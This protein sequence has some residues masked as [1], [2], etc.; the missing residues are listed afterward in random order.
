[1][2]APAHKAKIVEIGRTTAVI[3]DAVVRVTPARR[4]IAAGHHASVVSV[5]QCP[6]L[7]GGGEPDPPAEV[8]H[9]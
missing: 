7:R 3:L 4:S 5:A 2:V 6:S 1:M 9:L 8:E